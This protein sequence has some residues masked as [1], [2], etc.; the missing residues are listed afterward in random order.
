MLVAISGLSTNSIA[1]LIELVDRFDHLSLVR[2]SDARRIAD[3]QDGI[4]LGMEVHAL[5]LAW[6]EPAVPLPRCDG[7][8]LAATDR[9]QDDESG[10][11][12]RFASQSVLDP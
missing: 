4:T 10:Q 8:R 1:E 2:S 5:I 9:G 6:Q 3:I 7:L 11:I 12:L